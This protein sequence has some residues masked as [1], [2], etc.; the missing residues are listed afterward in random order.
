MKIIGRETE[1]ALVRNHLHMGRNLAIVGGEGVGKTALVKAAI[2]GLAD[3]LY[4]DDTSTLKRAC[5]PLLAQ[6]GLSVETADNLERKRALLAATRGRRLTFVFDHVR[7]VGPKLLSLLELLRESHPMIVVARDLTSG[8]AGHLKIILWEFDRLELKPLD[9]AA[10]AELV[11]AQI[12]QL[13]LMLPDAAQFERDVLRLGAGNPR[14]I[15]ELC[16]QA[17]QGR[18]VFGG[19]TSTQLVDLDRRINELKLRSDEAASSKRRSGS[20]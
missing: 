15:I 11:R 13:G 6:L 10:A 17:S 12:K 1:L 16:Q 2:A 4:C 5:E 9:H 20:S 18:Y 14:R 7:A 8:E 19:H 3:T